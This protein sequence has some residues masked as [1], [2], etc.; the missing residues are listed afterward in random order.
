MGMKKI[1]QCGNEKVLE[2]IKKMLDKNRI[3]WY[4]N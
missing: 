3:T 1:E 4:I 2:K